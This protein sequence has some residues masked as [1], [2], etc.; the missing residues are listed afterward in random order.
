MEP[1]LLQHPN[2]VREEEQLLFSFPEYAFVAR[3]TQPKHEVNE[4]LFES[5]TVIQSSHIIPV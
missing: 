4:P 2:A 3:S 1:E 5:M